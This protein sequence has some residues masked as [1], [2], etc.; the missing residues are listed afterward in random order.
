MLETILEYCGEIKNDRNILSIHRHL[1][2]EVEELADE[3]YNHIFGMKMGDDGIV[4]E[5]VDVALCSIDLAY[6]Y[7]IDNGI[8]PEECNRIITDAF[9]RKLDKWK[10]LYNQP[11]VED[12]QSS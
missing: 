2:G 8:Q 10:T 1:K 7:L 5:S 4:G 6:M 11:R 3:V 9:T 12:E